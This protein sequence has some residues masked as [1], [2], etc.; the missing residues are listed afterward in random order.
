MGHSFINKDGIDAF[1]YCENCN[2]YILF[3][4]NNGKYFQLVNDRDYKD[5]LLTCEEMI[6]KNI[7][8]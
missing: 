3:N 1:I 2:S 8:E 7:I 4:K 5:K 6:I